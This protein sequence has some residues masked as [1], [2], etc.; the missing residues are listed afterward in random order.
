MIAFGYAAKGLLTRDMT[1]YEVS[2]DG[3]LKREMW[4]ENPY[5]CMM[6]D[7]GITRDYALFHVV[8]IIGSL[9]AARGGHAAFRLRH[10]A[11]GLS[12]R[13]AAPRRRD[14]RRTSAGSSAT[15][16]SPATS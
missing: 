2:P 13:A 5:Y 4:F 7:F 8:P 12:R 6:H 16:A 9:G 10:H 11:A 15:I 3:E 14:G 1:Y